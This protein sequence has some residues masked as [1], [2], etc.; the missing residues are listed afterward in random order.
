M[1]HHLG[2]AGRDSTQQQAVSHRHPMDLSADSRYG[3]LLNRCTV[4][5][6]DTCCPFASGLWRLLKRPPPVSCL[7]VLHYGCIHLANAQADDAAM[8]PGTSIPAHTDE[9][10]PAAPEFGL[11]WAE[12]QGAMLSVCF[13]GSPGLPRCGDHQCTNRPMNW[14]PSA[15]SD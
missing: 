7:P 12:Q 15:S 8:T 13:Q 3:T 10:V 14:A 1:Q 11:L 6:H 9:P 2:T 4:A 5:R